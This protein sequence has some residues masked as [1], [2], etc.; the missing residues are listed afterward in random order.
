MNEMFAQTYVVDD[1]LSVREALEG[2]IRSAGMK[3]Q[4]FGSARE[5]LA[6]QRAEVPSCLVLDVDLPGLSGLDLQ[7]ELAKAN[8]HIPIIFLTGHGDIPMSVRAIKAGAIE[9]LT[10][11]FDDQH[12]GRA[13]CCRK[14]RGKSKSWPPRKRRYLFGAKQGPAMNWLPGKSMRA[15]AARTIPS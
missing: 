13:G 7:Q 5:F 12:L 14:S 11:P 10:K 6:G 8:I 9:F 4:S 3:V 1:D 2:L 15:A